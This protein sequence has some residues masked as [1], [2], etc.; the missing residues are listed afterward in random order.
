MERGNK[1][2]FIAT[3]AKS[4]IKTVTS[5]SRDKLLRVQLERYEE[6]ELMV[7]KKDS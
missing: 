3:R 5:F 7:I 6:D 1:M 4:L 2:V